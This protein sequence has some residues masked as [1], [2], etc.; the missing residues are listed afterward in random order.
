MNA[1]P[2]GALDFSLLALHDDPLPAL[3]LQ[4]NEAHTAGNEALAMQLMDKIAGENA[5]RER[6]AVSSFCY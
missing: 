1:Y 6:W 5:K 2:P 4:L 3:Q